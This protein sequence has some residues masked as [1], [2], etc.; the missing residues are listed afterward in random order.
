[1]HVQL[2]NDVC[3][4]MADMKVAAAPASPVGGLDDPELEG[5]DP[6]LHE[7]AAQLAQKEKALSGTAVGPLAF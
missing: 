6:S 5:L 7:S 1:M 4:Q 3:V 2:R